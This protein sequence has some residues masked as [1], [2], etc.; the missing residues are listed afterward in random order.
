MLLAVRMSLLVVGPIGSNRVWLNLLTNTSN[1]TPYCNE[2][3]SAVPKESMMP[4]M[5]EPS[6]AM[7][8]NTSPGRPSGYSPTHR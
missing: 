5:V 1:G 2:I 3:E 7:V 8:M 4:P 6:L